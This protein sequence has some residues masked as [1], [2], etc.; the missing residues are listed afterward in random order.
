MKEFWADDL[1]AKRGVTM[2]SLFCSSSQATGL[3]ALARTGTFP[4]VSESQSLNNPVQHVKK[5]HRWTN[6]NVSRH[7]MRIPN[8]LL[9]P[10]VAARLSTK[11]WNNGKLPGNVG[12]LSSEN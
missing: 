5:K 2:V 6:E 1:F 12:S 11:T 7:T 4:A 3:S 9:Q 10:W 8:V